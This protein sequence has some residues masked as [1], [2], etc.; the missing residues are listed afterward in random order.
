VLTPDQAE[1]ALKG[2][3]GQGD[4]ARIEG[5]VTAVSKV[6]DER[7]G[8]I[9]A[10]TVTE[11]HR[12]SGSII[13]LRG[14]PVGGAV[15]SVS[16]AWSSGTPVLAAGTGYAVDVDG[17]YAQITSWAG[18]WAPR[19]TVVYEAGRYATTALVAEPFVTAAQMLLQHHWRQS[20][21]GGS[22]TFGAPIGFLDS[23]LPS[24]GFPNAVRDLLVGELLPPAIA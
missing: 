4:R 5:L 7:C 8:P 22:E 15:T 16:E 11:L 6:L 14:L 20:D 2:V 12:P 10:R 3:K 18:H 23:G 1:K 24:F 17:P 19:V 21:G 9:V 13:F